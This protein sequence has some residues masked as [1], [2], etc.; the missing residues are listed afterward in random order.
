[1]T[2]S[3]FALFFMNMAQLA[4][5]TPSSKTDGELSSSTMIYIF[6]LKLT[7]FFNILFFYSF[8]LLVLTFSI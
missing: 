1:M 3:I 2:F 7:E 5:E 8:L 4:E 6:R